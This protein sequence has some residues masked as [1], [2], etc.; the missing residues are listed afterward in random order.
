MNEETMKILQ[1]LEAGKITAEE[2]HQLLEAI[3]RAAP[4]EAPTPEPTAG[5][6]ASQTRWPFPDIAGIVN[7][8][9]R[10]AFSEVERELSELNIPEMVG[11]VGTVTAQGARFMGAKLSNTN[12]LD[13]Q[14]DARTRFEGANL[15]STI[16]VDANLKG[17][18][19]R[20]A[21]LAFSN[22]TDANLENADLR[23]ANMSH[24]N[25]VDANLQNADMR[26]ANLSHGAYT[27]ADFRDCDLRK[28]DLSRS[29]MVDASFRG[30][31]QP[32]L[33]LRGVKMPGVKYTGGPVSEGVA[34][35]TGQGEE[36][37][38][39]ESGAAA[40]TEPTEP[41][42]ESAPSEAESTAT[43]SESPEGGQEPKR[44]WPWT[45]RRGKP[46]L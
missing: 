36:A 15:E 4:E 6:A 22:F 42:A 11:T 7:E 32:G 19:L 2:A 20:G 46:K 39:L 40:A 5:G 27:D 38:G 30:V 21:N 9:L 28:A 25:F 31:H 10:E 45:S 37:T 12:L 16:F 29:N 33:S 44:E 3:N 23:G 13:A 14:M 24:S 18:D 43:L 8:A 17:A 1:M 26:G 35:A 41:D 34:E